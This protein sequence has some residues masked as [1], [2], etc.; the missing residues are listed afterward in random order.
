M[1]SQSQQLKLIANRGKYRPSGLL[2]VSHRDG[3]T[4]DYEGIS[5]VGDRSNFSLLSNTDPIEK[6]GVVGDK[7]SN[8]MTPNSVSLENSNLAPIDDRA[9][10][11][12]KLDTR[13]DLTTK[14]LN[15]KLW[16]N[17][18]KDEFDLI[19]K[20]QLYGAATWRT[21]NI[22]LLQPAIN[23][24][25]GA[26][27]A[28]N[29]TRNNW[30]LRFK[31]RIFGNTTP[32][33]ADGLAVYYSTFDLG[34]TGAG[35]GAPILPTGSGSFKVYIDTYDNATNSNVG[36]PKVSV[37]REGYPPILSGTQPSL[38][39]EDWK[40]F[41]ITHRDNTLS[42]TINGIDF[43]SNLPTGISSDLQYYFRISASTGASNGV[44]EIQS[45]TFN[46]DKVKKR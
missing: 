41:S 1:P 30:T 23:G 11:P 24:S 13:L 34:G 18:E 2:N 26:I 33:L 37:E 44:H 36:M 43:A 17:G 19:L 29:F 39:G 25:F 16:D 35:G 22:V 6:L 10:M 8:P 5:V 46:S 12:I 40:N 38:I 45:V 9:A 7:Q 31:Y 15:Y 27:G 4:N 21:R 32:L 14:A 20:W 28:K 3:R 42:V